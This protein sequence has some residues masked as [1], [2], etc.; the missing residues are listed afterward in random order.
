MRM[1]VKS[2]LLFPA[3][4]GI[5]LGS[6]EHVLGDRRHVDMLIWALVLGLSVGVWFPF[7]LTPYLR[8][9]SKRD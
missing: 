6:L 7:L 2:G 9:F 4:L 8:R 1:F 5:V 3:C